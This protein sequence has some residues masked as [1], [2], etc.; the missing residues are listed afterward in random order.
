MFFPE[1]QPRVYFY[2]QPADLRRSFDSDMPQ[3]R[4]HPLDGAQ[5][6]NKIG[7]HCS[8]CL[9][10][11]SRVVPQAIELA[12]VQEDAPLERPD[13]I[14]AAISQRAALHPSTRPHEVSALI[15][16]QLA[17]SVSTQSVTID[18]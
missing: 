12:R 13:K 9:R 17:Q 2:G 4:G 16:A 10:G 14:A 1:G 5:S 3:T 18:L 11:L 6:S 7:P 8:C 15:A